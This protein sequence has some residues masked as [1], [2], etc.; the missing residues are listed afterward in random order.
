MTSRPLAPAGAV[1]LG[2]ALAA[3]ARPDPEAAMA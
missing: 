1:L 2:L 3:P